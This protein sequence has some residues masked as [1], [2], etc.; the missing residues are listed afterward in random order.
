MCFLDSRLHSA[1]V[2]GGAAVV[3]PSPFIVSSQREA[4]LALTLQ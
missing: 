2:A 4:K 1:A 3:I